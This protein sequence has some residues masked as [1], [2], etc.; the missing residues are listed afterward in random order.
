MLKDHFRKPLKKDHDS[1]NTILDIKETQL[2][3]AYDVR[4]GSI[5]RPG[6][7]EWYSIPYVDVDQNQ[8]KKFVETKCES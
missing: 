7:D 8:L 6:L 2:K 1:G 5:L 3:D 4:I